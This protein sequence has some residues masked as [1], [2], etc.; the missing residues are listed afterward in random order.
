MMESGDQFVIFWRGKNDEVG[1]NI[2]PKNGAFIGELRSYLTRLLE[3]IAADRI[4]EIQ[5]VPPAAPAAVASPSLVEP[6]HKSARPKR[7]R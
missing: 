4:K 6:T 7:R 2:S 5:A 3:D 1:K